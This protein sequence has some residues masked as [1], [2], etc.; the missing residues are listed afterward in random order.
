MSA[1]GKL[2]QE[3]IFLPSTGPEVLHLKRWYT[4]PTGPPV[5]FLHGSIENGRIFYSKS[6]KGLAPWLAEQ[7]FDC[8]VADQR[9]RGESSP[10]ISRKTQWGLQEMIWEDFPVFFDAI[11]ERKPGQSVQW[12]CHS[13]AGVNCLAW[14]ARKTDVYPISSLV[15]FGAKRRI[16]V[17]NW[18]KFWNYD[19]GWTVVGRLTHLLYG[20]LAATKLGFGSENESRGSHMGIHRWVV[21]KEWKDPDDGFD[22]LKALPE[23]ALPPTYS[24]TGASDDYLGH[25]IDCQILLDE[26]GKQPQMSY[27]TIGKDSGYLHDYDH[28]N[29]LTHPDA[30]KDHFLEVLDFLKKHR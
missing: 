2:Q 6:G 24:I 30:R 10:K 23:T 14:L 29:L 4:D 16:T 19:I 13:W 1:G 22:F 17:R 21:D 15:F 11:V 26:C 8:Y 9:G 18:K 12:V 27:K 3:S 7:G 25:A 20:Y 28:I 5:F